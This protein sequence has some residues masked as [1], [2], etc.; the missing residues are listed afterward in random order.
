MDDNI[1]SR[2]C[3]ETYPP[4]S[5]RDIKSTSVRGWPDLLL[6][7]GVCILVGGECGLFL[8]VGG[9]ALWDVV[10][11]DMRDVMD[12]GFRLRLR[13]RKHHLTEPVF[14]KSFSFRVVVLVPIAV[15]T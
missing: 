11:N 2:V 8:V 3:L 12:G 15:D 10:L 9:G 7:D 4:R 14:G 6:T 1:R 13:L 5:E